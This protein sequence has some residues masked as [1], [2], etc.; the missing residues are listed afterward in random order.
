MDTVTKYRT[1]SL[2]DTHVTYCGLD[3]EAERVVDDTVWRMRKWQFTP[4]A[5]QCIGQVQHFVKLECNSV[6]IFN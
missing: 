3:S 1:E 4:A 6:Y 2:S 5:Y